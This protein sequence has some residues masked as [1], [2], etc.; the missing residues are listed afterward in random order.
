M[1]ELSPCPAGNGKSLNG[2][3]REQVLR[4]EV[5]VTP[6]PLFQCGKEIREGAR[7]EAGQAAS[8]R[9]TMVVEAWAKILAVELEKKGEIQ[10]IRQ[11]FK[12][13]SSH[14]R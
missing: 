9:S 4:S 7:K 10:E 11:T 5:P 1:T 14:V 12:S 6:C 13:I 3:C 2:F 8:A